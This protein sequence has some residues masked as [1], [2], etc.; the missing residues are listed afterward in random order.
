[1][2]V[3]SLPADRAV[4]PATGPVCA[5]EKV[6]ITITNSEVGVNYQLKDLSNNPYSAVTSGTGSDLVILSAT[7]PSSMTLKVVATNASTP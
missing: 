6:N 1:M 7:I 3:N 4:T 2:T 5:G